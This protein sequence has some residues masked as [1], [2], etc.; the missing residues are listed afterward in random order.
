[1]RLRARERL[2]S[3]ESGA[4]CSTR[5]ISFP[6]R[7]STRSPGYDAAISATSSCESRPIAILAQAPH[8]DWVEWAWPPA[9]KVC[10]K[11]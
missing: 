4:R 11:R 3:V 1:M 9:T 6:A 7:F 8:L 5:S 10:A 2:S